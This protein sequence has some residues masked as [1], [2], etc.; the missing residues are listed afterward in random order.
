M[1]LFI[2]LI[3]RERTTPEEVLG[4]VVHEFTLT[5]WKFK[6]CKEDV[7]TPEAKHVV[8]TKGI[9]T[10][11]TKLCSQKARTRN[12]LFFLNKIRELVTSLLCFVSTTATMKLDLNSRSTPV[13]KIK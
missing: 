6:I 3:V 5:S 8:I 12:G 13:T 4:N 9:D 2:K 7:G 10:H 11:T 1:S